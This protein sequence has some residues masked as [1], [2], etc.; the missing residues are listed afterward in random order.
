L[1]REANRSACYGNNNPILHINISQQPCISPAR[2]ASPKSTTPPPGPA[3]PATRKT[4][5]SNPPRPI[6]RPLSPKATASPPLSTH[7]C[8][9]R[10]VWSWRSNR[11]SRRR[12]KCP[13]NARRSTSWATAGGARTAANCTTAPRSG[14]RSPDAS[15]STISPS[16]W[17]CTAC[18][19]SGHF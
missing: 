12:K 15:C 17:A 14:S 16:C 5:T 4:P 11:T 7:R 6:P 10:V 2:T 18:G 8:G 13:T 3:P 9:C 19:E 1:R